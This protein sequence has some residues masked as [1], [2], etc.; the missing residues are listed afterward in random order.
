MHQYIE[1]LLQ[2]DRLYTAL[3]VAGRPC[4]VPARPGLYAWYFNEAPP[5]VDTTACHRLDG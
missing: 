3:D 2:P 4:P 5:L 1:R